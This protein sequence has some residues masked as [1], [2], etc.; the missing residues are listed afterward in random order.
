VGVTSLAAAGVARA[1]AKASRI[2]VSEWALAFITVLVI[3]P[4]FVVIPIWTYVIYYPVLAIAAGVLGARLIVDAFHEVVSD[5]HRR[6]EANTTRPPTGESREDES[7][8]RLTAAFAKF[9]EEAERRESGSSKR[10]T[11][12]FE[13]F[14]EAEQH[15]IPVREPMSAEMA[16]LLAQDEEFLHLREERTRYIVELVELKQISPLSAEQQRRVTELGKLKQQ[17]ED[18]M[19]AK[20]RRARAQGRATS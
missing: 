19:E 12:A 5:R 8:K 18:R 14:S 3:A 6:S 11:V 15:M 7:S 10:M 17:T 4:L 2:R 13:P 1:T 16:K 20:I 9:L